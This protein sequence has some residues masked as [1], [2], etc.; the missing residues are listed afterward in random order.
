MG[1]VVLALLMCVQLL[2]ATH[3][4]CPANWCVH[5]YDHLLCVKGVDER[6]EDL[7][8]SRPQ[9]IRSDP[10]SPGTSHFCADDFVSQAVQ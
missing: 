3:Q 5:W 2:K 6:L 1:S 7:L 4:P 8:A 10:D 9:Q